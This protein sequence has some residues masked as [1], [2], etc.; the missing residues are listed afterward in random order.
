MLHAS[1][2]GPRTKVKLNL[3]AWVPARTINYV[4][5]IGVLDK[6]ELLIFATLFNLSCCSMSTLGTSAGAPVCIFVALVIVL[7]KTLRRHLLVEI[8]L[9]GP[10]FVVRR[11]F[12]HRLAVGYDTAGHRAGALF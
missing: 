5:I 1:H 10:D 7:T 4:S 3:L 2:A 8:R 12:A 9:D 6:M 11:T